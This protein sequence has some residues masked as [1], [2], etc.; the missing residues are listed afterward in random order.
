MDFNIKGPFWIYKD[1]IKNFI[2][3]YSNRRIRL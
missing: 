3:L 2:V 1:T